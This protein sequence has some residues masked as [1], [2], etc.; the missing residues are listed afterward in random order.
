MH[1]RFHLSLRSRE[2]H[3]PYED[4]LH[5]TCSLKEQAEAVGSR[6]RPRHRPS[7]SIKSRNLRHLICNLYAAA[8]KRNSKL[9][10]GRDIHLRS[11]GTLPAIIK[12][13]SKYF[14]SIPNK[15]PTRPYSVSGN[16]HWGSATEEPNTES[17]TWLRRLSVETRSSIFWALNDF[18]TCVLVRGRR[19]RTL[20]NV[21]GLVVKQR[22]TTEQ[23]A[24]DGALERLFTIDQIAQ[25]GGPCRSKL[26]QDIKLGRLKA[27]KFGRATRITESAWAAYLKSAPTL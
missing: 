1:S 27:L 21:G 26:Y 17:G 20:E 11:T 19:G 6:K 23:K 24:P 5:A 4:Y 8:E 13:F 3:V 16:T 9:T 25:L 15:Y 7:G 18:F 12:I 10:L 2:Q 22:D 14:P